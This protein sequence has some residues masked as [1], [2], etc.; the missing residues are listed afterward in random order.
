MS[1]ERIVVLGSSS[2]AGKSTFARR[3]GDI[4]RVPVH[5]LDVLFWK[6][7]WVESAPDEFAQAQSVRVD[8]PCWIIEGNYTSTYHLRES[9]ADTLIYLDMPLSVCLWRVVKRRVRY[10]H[11]S[12]PD[13]APG[14]PEKIDA[15]FL[16]FILRTYHKR[17]HNMA[18]RV[19]TFHQSGRSAIILKGH[20]QQQQFLEKLAL[21]TPGL[22]SYIHPSSRGTLK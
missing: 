16:W 20:R 9:R 12:R 19:R 13:I 6:P 5:H 8:Q 14:C 1:M 10:R 2:G 7:G 4:L 22:D 18:R 17:R 15:S 11:A 21:K 3:L